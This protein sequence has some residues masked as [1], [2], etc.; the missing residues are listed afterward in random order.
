MVLGLAVLAWLAAFSQLLVTSRLPRVPF[1]DNG[2]LSEAGHL[3][4]S[5]LV[6]LQLILL[7]PGRRVGR[8]VATGFA[9]A[10]VF[11]VGME[12][13]Q[14]LRPVR[15][16]QLGDTLLDV[17][18]V[19]AGTATA[20]AI[21]RSKVSAQRGRIVVALITIGAAATGQLVTDAASVIDRVPS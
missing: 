20:W 1:V 9:L 16:Y 4:G 7:M 21:L 17:I 2:R 14:E 6:A 11:V 3:V 10:A 15:A 8:A 18:G 5:F 12:V 13:V 19:L